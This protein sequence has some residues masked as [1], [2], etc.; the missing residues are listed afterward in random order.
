MVGRSVGRLK[1]L[2]IPPDQLSIVVAQTPV[3]VDPS[4][5]E[6][7]EQG[8]IA[9]LANETTGEFAALA[10]V[11]GVWC[12]V[13]HTTVSDLGPIKSGWEER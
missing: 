6:G 9:A 7:F 8:V 4:L 3:E 1:D 11:V 13:N 12:L 5:V 2:P 10:D